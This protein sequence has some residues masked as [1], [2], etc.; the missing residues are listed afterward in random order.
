MPRGI[1]LS[2]DDQ[3]EIASR[4]EA[5][6]PPTALAKH[7]GI[8][9]PAVYK[10]I[11]RLGVAVHGRTAEVWRTA[12]AWRNAGGRRNSGAWRTAEVERLICDRYRAGEKP[13][14]IAATID[15]CTPVAVHNILEKHGVPKHQQHKPK[16]SLAADLH[17]EACRLYQQGHSTRDL[18]E[19]FNTSYATVNRVLVSYGIEIRSGSSYAGDN[20]PG[21]IAAEAL[22]QHPRQCSLYV[23]DLVGCPGFSKVG[24]AFDVRQRAQGSKGQYGDEHLAM[25]FA[26]RQEAFFLEQAI[27][28]ATRSCASCPDAL[29]DW[30][31]SSE[32]RALPAEDLTAIAMRLADEMEELG[33]WDFAAARVPM[34]AAQRAICQQRALQGAPACPAA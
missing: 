16:R 15:G 33:V 22:F 30:G 3:L 29:A 23:F 9:Q 31:G 20:V 21:A 8:S 1:P 19:R 4:Y 24:I 34:M 26:T 17:G 12:G 28:D 25:I 11:K 6:E 32:V 27:L 18:A 7:Y 10:V 2:D 5:G 14:A 13:T